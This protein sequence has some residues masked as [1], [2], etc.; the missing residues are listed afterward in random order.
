[1][2][3]PGEATRAGQE[4]VRHSVTGYTHNMVS[5]AFLFSPIAS[6]SPPR[7]QFNPAT[8]CLCPFSPSLF[9]SHT[10]THTLTLSLSFHRSCCVAARCECS[11]CMCPV[12]W[13]IRGLS[14][15]PLVEFHLS[16]SDSGIVFFLSVT[17]RFLFCFFHRVGYSPIVS[18]SLIL[19]PPLF[20]ALSASYVSDPRILASIFNPER[21]V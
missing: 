15:S 10:H 4:E 14:L 18:L 11:C 20:P 12:A 2:R 17:Y 16:L 1:M 5:Q 19:S 13:A 3:H 21:S 8:S 6:Y 9:L 7:W